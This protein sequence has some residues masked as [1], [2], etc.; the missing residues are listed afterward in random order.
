MI[1]VERVATMAPDTVE[2]GDGHDPRSCGASTISIAIIPAK[3]NVISQEPKDSCSPAAI[4]LT[5]NTE[6]MT[7]EVVDGGPGKRRLWSFV[8]DLP[9]L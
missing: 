9:I 1:E 7:N 5:G 4:I 6:L 2:P 3:G 8:D